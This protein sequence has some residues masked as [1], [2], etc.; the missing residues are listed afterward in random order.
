ML[1]CTGCEGGWWRVGGCK[2]EDEQADR[3]VWTW[4]GWSYR[5]RARQVK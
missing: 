5:G 2:E 4:F 1:E 3:E